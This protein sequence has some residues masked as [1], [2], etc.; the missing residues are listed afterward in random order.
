MYAGIGWRGRGRLASL[1][2]FIL[3]PGLRN[4]RVVLQPDPATL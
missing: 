1:A 2:L 4:S 3:P